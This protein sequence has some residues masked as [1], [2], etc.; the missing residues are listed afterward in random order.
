[1]TRTAP[2]PASPRAPEPPRRRAA[3]LRTRL[4]DLAPGLGLAAAGVAASMTAAFLLPGMSALLIAIV[5]GVLLRNTVPLSPRFEAGL[6][7]AAKPL[8]RL[9][10][11][12]LGLQLVLGDILD[13]G[14]GVIVVVVAIVVIGIASTLLIGRLL[15][16]SATQRLLIACGFSICGAAAVAAVDG[17]VE[18]EEEEVV[19]AV[20][21]VVVFGTLMI[22]LI[23]LAA[24]LLGLSA[25]QA[26][27][28][29]GGSI[30]EVAQVVAVGGA[31]GGTGLAVAVVVK[32]A[33][34]L[35]LA[36]VLAVIS[37]QRRRSLAATPGASSGKRPPIIPLFVVGFIAMVAVR[38]LGWV[39]D[40]VVAGAGVAQTVLLAAAMFALGTGVRFS[41]FRRVGVRP[42]A[43]AGASTLI[44]TGVALAGVVAVG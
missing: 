5:L 19:T 24:S 12:L 2:T 25:Q 39:P 34:V 16:I 8:L 42:F 23:P 44:V 3:R 10:V 36:P 32:L 7:F 38:S 13:L 37:V 6:A 20:A 26:G 15:G 14:A 28:W 27:M 33:R 4:A 30:H 18:A 22:P 41:M 17:V 11:V 40:V 9:G 43:L 35:M 29:A 1:M 21:L 31:L